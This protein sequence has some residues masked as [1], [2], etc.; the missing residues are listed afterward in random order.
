MYFDALL[1]HLYSY[2]FLECLKQEIGYNRA[3]DV[4]LLRNFYG[5]FRNI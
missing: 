3:K 1:I 4:R 5:I 2:I